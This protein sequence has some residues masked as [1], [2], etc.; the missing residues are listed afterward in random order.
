M[1]LLMLLFP[2]HSSPPYVSPTEALRPLYLVHCLH[3][4]DTQ[5]RGPCHA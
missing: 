4:R 1:S 5:L 2:L 3:I